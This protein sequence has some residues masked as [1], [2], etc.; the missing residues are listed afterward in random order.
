MKNLCGILDDIGM[1]LDDKDTVRELAMKSSRAII[2][3]SGNAVR[4][5][6]KNEDIGELITDAKEETFRLKSVLGDHPDL[7]HS[8]FVE[9]SFQELAEA[10][11]L[12]AIL[13]NEELPVPKSL[14]ITSVSYLL[15]LSDVV[16]ELRRLALNRMKDGDVEGAWT[17]LERMEIIY[18]GIMRFDYPHAMV[19]I[20]RKQDIA[21]SLLEK[22]RGELVVAQS[23]VDLR[24]D[25]ESLKEKF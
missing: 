14:G 12:Q 24:K 11:I 19:A 1:E 8:G 22:T 4:G 5:L 3:M 16:G 6:H 21:R 9:N 2:R 15:G 17:Y 7:Y 20:R 25:I 13:K 10:C 23:N 18:D